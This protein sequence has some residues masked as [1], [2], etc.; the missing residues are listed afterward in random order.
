MPS[1]PRLPLSIPHLAGNEWTYVKECLD[2]GWVSSVGPFVTR[3][4]GA[5][6][7]YAGV[8]HAVA[9]INGTAALHVALLVAGVR[10]G[11]EVLV[12]ALT[13]V[14]TVNA[15]RYCGAE[16][17]FMDADPGTWQMDVAKLRRFLATACD[18][19][20]GACVNRAT[21]RRVRAVMP[22]HL[23]GLACE[24]DTIVEIARAHALQVVED[25]TEGMGVRYRGRHVGTFGDVGAFSFNGNK[26]VTTGG[27]GM[28][29]TADAAQ[30]RYARYLTT[31]A[32]DDELEYFHN[33]IGYNYRLTNVL[34]ALGLAQIEQLDAF[35]ET[36][37]AIAA[38][39]HAAF[40]GRSGVVPMPLPPH[41]DAT[42]WLYTMLLKPG[43]SLDSR[44]AVI[45]A[46]HA[47][48]IEA[49]PLWYPVP[50]LPP[51]RN[52]ESFEVEHAID[53]HARAVS[54]PSSAGMSMADVD[55]C[56]AAVNAAVAAGGAC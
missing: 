11:D 22:V 14:A 4:E 19:R 42:Y 56:I 50:L 35:V 25:A 18:V 38:R 7:A 3:F 21:G 36:R 45:R 40:S 29:V 23:L 34:S 48:G 20:D 44:R 13:F 46:L 10:P 53:L 52:A 16:P 2:T 5:V 15:V 51:Y 26:I 41:V 47:Q 55:R 8:P 6:A 37:R 49:R 54:L 39:Y 17:V 12:P 1:E 30:A 24:I 31:Q 28:L 27:G 9:I 43:T 33:E 32:K